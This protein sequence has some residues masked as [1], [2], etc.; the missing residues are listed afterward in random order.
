MTILQAALEKSSRSA[1]PEPEMKAPKAGAT[2]KPIPGP[3]PILEVRDLSLSFIQY[4]AG[5]VQRELKVITDLNLTIDPGE[6]L[7]VVG[8]S[9]S[10]KSLLAHAVLGI[11]P[12]NACLSGTLR[13][14][15]E[16]LD[17]RRQA[18]LRQREIALVPQSVNFLDPLMRVGNQVRLASRNGKAICAQRSAFARYGLGLHVERLF[19]FQ[20]SGGMARRVLAATAAVSG[21]RLIIADEPTPGLHPEVLQ[22]TLSHLQELAAEGRGIMLIT[23]DIDIALTIARRI[24]VFYAGAT[25]EIAPVSDFSG[26]GEALRHPYT[27]A[28]WKALPQNDFA[29]IPGFQPPPD[30]LPKGCLFAPRCP[31]KTAECATARPPARGLRG[32]MVRCWHAA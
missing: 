24:A 29:P 30:A 9:G 12:V 1:S 8:E 21:A 5:L 28:L 27:K 11:L 2:L 14:A 16:D 22:E 25:L 31:E 3:V 7:A 17:P 26:R 20:L 15:G 23:H 32:G 6:I 19:P 13:F 10:G 4:S 18:L